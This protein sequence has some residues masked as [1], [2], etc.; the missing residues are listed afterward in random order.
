[1][2]WNGRLEKLKNHDLSM[3]RESKREDYS[4]FRMSWIMISIVSQTHVQIRRE[5]S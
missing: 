4:L 5:T 2:F 1:M 3:L